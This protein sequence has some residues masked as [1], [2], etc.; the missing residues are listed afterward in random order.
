[1]LVMVEAW[2]AW[3]RRVADVRV[4]ITTGMLTAVPPKCGHQP[5]RDSAASLDQAKYILPRSRISRPYVVAERD[6][7]AGKDS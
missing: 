5:I 3:G 2:G 1:M 6:E 4:A 7:S